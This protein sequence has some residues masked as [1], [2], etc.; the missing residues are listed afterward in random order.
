VPTLA[1]LDGVLMSESSFVLVGAIAGAFGVRG[2]IRVRS[3]TGDPQAIRD[4]G[5]LMDE[6]GKIILTPKSW[7]VVP[8]GMA[9]IAA[10]VPHREAAMALR[11]T[12]LFVP[13]AKLPPEAEDEFYFVDL[14][15]LPVEALDGAPLGRV[16]AVIGGPQDLLEI[17]GTPGAKARWFLP[18]TKL[19]VPVVELGKRLVAD[20]PGGLIPWAGAPKDM[21]ENSPPEDEDPT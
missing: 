6:K 1:W 12:K 17:A 5:P 21:D 3:F 14:I 2:E 15:G 9:M 7:R 4:Y 16:H 18:F 13:R 20:V 19:T 11:N 10:E 8:N